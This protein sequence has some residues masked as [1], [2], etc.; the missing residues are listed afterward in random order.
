MSYDDRRWN[1]EDS[2]K[3]LK[4]TNERRVEELLNINN[5]YVRTQRHLEENSDIASPEQLKHSFKIQN[6]REERMENLKNLIADNTQ[7]RSENIDALEKRIEYTGGYIEHNSEDM[8]PESLE[9]AK[10]K[11]A[12]RKEQL[13]NLLD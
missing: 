2:R 11:Q 13:E 9:N 8:D 4:Q 3:D 5:R 6:D 1:Q 10:E 12:N 7:S